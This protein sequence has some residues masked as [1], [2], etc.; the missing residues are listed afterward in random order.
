MKC[1]KAYQ[2]WFKSLPVTTESEVNHGHVAILVGL[3]RS[4]VGTT[5]AFVMNAQRCLGQSED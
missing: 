1:I 3:V 5:L 4:H 2:A